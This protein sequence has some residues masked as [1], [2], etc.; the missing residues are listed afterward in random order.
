MIRRYCRKYFSVFIYP[1]SIYIGTYL[2]HL[3]PKINHPPSDQGAYRIYTSPPPSDPL[4]ANKSY[5][6]NLRAGTLRSN[7]ISNSSNVRPRLSGNLAQHQTKQTTLMPP[8]RNPALPR[9]FA[10]SELSMYGMA[11][12]KTMEARACTAVV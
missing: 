11:T 7:K 9:Q 1:V 2:K 3:Y 8:N 5:S 4:S 10:W 12:V 6:L